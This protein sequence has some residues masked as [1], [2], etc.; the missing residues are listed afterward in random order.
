LA[1]DATGTPTSLGI[2][3]YNTAVDAPSGLGFNATMDALDTILVA[4]PQKPAGI[5]TGEAV[6]WN[7][8]AWVRSSVTKLGLASIAQGGA[9][10]DQVLAW[11][12]SAWAAADGTSPALTTSLPGTPADGE[13]IHYT[14]SL[15]APTYIWHLRYISAAS[16]YKWY[17]VGAGREAVTEVA[18]A[19]ATTSSSYAALST[20]GPTFTTPL[21]GDWIVTV[22]FR[23]RGA[24][25]ASRIYM[26][27]DIGGTG[28]VDANAAQSSS[29]LSSTK[30]ERAPA[31]KSLI[32]GVSASTALTSKYKSVD[33]TSMTWSERRISVRPFR[34]G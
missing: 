14:D 11:N 23:F 31:F 1:T 32:T 12:G 24:A 29:S 5:V 4:M 20:A 33:S 3:K 7:G 9:T 21:A 17:C 26:S 30:D 15:T 22:E 13:E 25:G 16:T 2:P 10:T 18:T 34:V 28:A 27:F 6:I 8:S 19:E